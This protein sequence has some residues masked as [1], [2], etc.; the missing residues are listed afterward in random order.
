MHFIT[1]DHLRSMDRHAPRKGGGLHRGML[2]QVGLDTPM[3]KSVARDLGEGLTT[4]GLGVIHGRMGAMPEYKGIPLDFAVAVAAK[5]IQ[6][7]PIA[8]PAYIEAAAETVGRGAFV[9]FTASVGQMLGQKWRAKAV[10]LTGAPQPSTNSML[11]FNRNVTQGQ[12]PHD[13]RVYGAYRPEV[14]RTAIHGRV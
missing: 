10:G 3:K 14:L 9:Y 12:T 1:R 6:Y 8:K 5:L 2:R 7:L 13:A 11:D 4:L